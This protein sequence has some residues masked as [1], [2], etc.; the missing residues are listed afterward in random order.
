MIKDGKRT[1]CCCESTHRMTR[2]TRISILLAFFFAVDK[3]VAFLRQVIIARQ[4]GMSTALDAFNVAN[5]IPDLLYALISGGALA[6]AFIPVLTATLSQEG[7]DEAWK[8]FSRVANLV[9]LVTSALAVI[10]AII[11]GPLVR[12]QMGVAPGFGVNE[13]NTVI[14]LMRLNL[15][16]TLIFS[17]SGLVM[18]GLQANQHFLFPALAPAFY[19]FGQIFGALVLSPVKGYSLAGITLPAY[20]WGV[21]G[22]VAGVILGS[23]LHLGIQIPGL[24]RYGF[25]WVPSLGLKTE[26][27]KRV[28]RLMGPRVLTVF[29]IQ[30]IFL[31]RDNLASRLTPGAVTALTYGWM[32]QQVPETLIGTAIGTALLPTLSEL[33]AHGDEEQFHATIQRAVRVLVGITLPTAVVMGMGLGPLLATVFKFGPEGTQMLLWT[34]RGFLAGLV[35]HSLMEVASRAFYSRQDART[36]L[37]AGGVN[38]VVYILLGLLLYRPLGPAG[39]SLTDTI[40]F[41]T[42]ALV[43]L[44]ILSRRL[45]RRIDFGS[46]I[47][48]ALLAAA[49]GGAVVW[50]LQSLALV[51]R[52]ALVGSLFALVAGM[53]VALPFIW[54]EVRL[55]LK[56]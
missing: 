51:Q 12:S 25:R 3:V 41:T 20:G 27:V 53:A 45:G 36:P 50:G 6:L 46:G 5:N 35:G 16:A 34:T 39:I 49:A 38:M 13:Q 26:P 33:A 37:I 47:W 1:G 29:S 28:L 18:S 21:H 56:L 44:A 31:V 30:V 40:C 52:F 19:N 42:Q 22:L 17:I 9:F 7:R 15:I 55:L 32:L 23:M 24:I 8:L 4:F 43:L 14:E 54:N 2:L 10:V 48:R 11:A